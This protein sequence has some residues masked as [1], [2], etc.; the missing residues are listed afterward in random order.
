MHLNVSSI[1]V[2]SVVQAGTQVVVNA[3]AV[4]AASLVGA[5]KITNVGVPVQTI[6][7]RLASAC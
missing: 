2:L 3:P 4:E 5:A 1:P 6:N 7:S